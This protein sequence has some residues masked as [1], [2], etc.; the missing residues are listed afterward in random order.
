MKINLAVA[1]PLFLFVIAISL[2]MAPGLRLPYIDKNT[3]AYFSDSITKA[4]IAY[5]ACRG[6]NAAVSVIKESKVQIEPAGIGVSLAAGQVLDPLY[7]MTERA[8]DIIITAIVSLGIQKL[9]YEICVAFAPPLLG[10]SIVLAF[11]LSL[12]ENEKARALKSIV[13]K[14]MI[15]IAVA[16]FCLPVSSIANSYLQEHFFSQRIVETKD[17]LAISSPE[18]ER[19]MNCRMPEIDGVVG[20]VKNGLGFVADKTAELG[21]VLR[22]ITKNMGSLVSNLLKLSSLY[23]AIFMVQVILL[24]VGSFWILIRITNSLFSAD[25]PYLIKHAGLASKTSPGT[26]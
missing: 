6:V 16:R 17:Q 7:D 22:S 18:L 5:T 21:T 14:C 9:A 10:V 26:K 25:L 24:P 8:S 19:L 13:V 15:V 12:F 3:D 20:T 11:L 4:G 23:V 2:F 1:R